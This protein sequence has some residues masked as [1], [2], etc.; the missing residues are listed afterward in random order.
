ML[1]FS[2]TIPFRQL[3]AGIG[4]STYRLNTIVVGLELVA[5]GGKRPEHLQVKWNE[6]AS[7][8]MARQV[9]D[10]AKNFALVSATVYA[11][12]LFDT[13]LRN[14]AAE[15][16]LEFQAET[17]HVVGR[18]GSGP[19]GH[20]YSMRERALKLCAELDIKADPLPSTLDLL[21]KWRNNLV[22]GSYGRDRQLNQDVR[23]ELIAG[24][25]FLNQNYA[26]I[27]IGRT[28][29]A[30]EDGGHPTRKDATVLLACVQNLARLI[31]E[32][33]VR[34]ALP[35]ETAMEALADRFLGQR[36]KPD[37]SD[38]RGWVEFCDIWAR[39]PQDRPKTFAKVL[40][41][42]AITPVKKPISPPL[43]EAYVRDLAR[44]NR[45][46]AAMRLQLTI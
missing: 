40:G 22:H 19:G 28:L 15:T 9:A 1:A 2:R 18:H 20:E 8:A 43:T 13:F 5:L 16:W 7:A 11:A 29:K 14:I 23:A 26:N 24:A 3:Q 31:D 41:Q 27:D 42:V 30:F 35:N 21:A 10:Q 25:E 33:A 45:E 37:G 44:L 34:R 17:V 38:R 46:E 6:P 39:A 12:D 4:R 32:S 36:W